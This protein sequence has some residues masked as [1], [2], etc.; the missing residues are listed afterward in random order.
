MPTDPDV[1]VALRE[2]GAL[3]VERLFGALELTVAGLAPPDAPN[4]ATHL[5]TPHAAGCF[6]VVSFG[7]ESEAVTAVGTLEQMRPGTA[8]LV[9]S[10][11]RRLAAHPLVVPL[12][13]VPPEAADEAAVAA[14]HGAAYLAL[15]VTT[16]G[17][18]VDQA[19]APLSVVGRE[20]AIVGLGIGTAAVLLRETP[21]PPAYAPALLAKIQAG[22]RLPR[23]SFGRVRVAGS[24]FALID[25]QLPAT[26]DFGDN[27]L[28]AVVDG[29]AMI[30][31]GIAEGSVGVELS[32]LAEAPTEV[33]SG[34]E[35]IVEV[36]WRAGE[37]QASVVD[38][39]GASD[40]PLCRQTPPWPG[41]YRLRVHARGRDE[42]DS[43]Y[44]SYQLVVWAA[45][46]APQVVHRRTD[47]LGHRLRGEPEPVRPP[48]PERAYRWIRRT[49]LSV[50][51]TV[52]VV[53][54]MTVEEVLR[55]FGADP[56]RPEA[57]RDL[58]LQSNLRRY[59]DAWVA[60]LDTAEAVLAVEYNGF[61]GS[62]GA[63]LRAASARGRAASMFW[64]V[65][66]LTQL[67]FAERGRLLASFEPWA[68]VDADPAVAAALAEIDFADL[69]DRV[70]KGL[71]AVERF[72][73]RGITPDD[74]AQIQA[75]GVGFRISDPG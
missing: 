70:P 57:I 15:A 21:M 26:V 52:T 67:S 41:D 17:T 53:T 11:A 48:R 8:D 39:D 24:R 69:D 62:D 14:W 36:S 2:R 19:H 5:P 72:T 51:A 60:V 16:A 50:A 42:A 31:T 23:Q 54:G 37:G 40:P 44:E 7:H 46:A 22:Y 33:E 38:P 28:V 56:D 61:R 66:A 13:A 74:F 30:R 9:L 4:L 58:E 18:V 49:P 43:E 63:V 71:V 75:A 29:G 6:A 20:A 65:N 12:L 73:G 35:D 27:G 32:V 47:R 59:L 34:W 55:A 64:N 10:L 3:P 68:A 45:P 1:L 25:R